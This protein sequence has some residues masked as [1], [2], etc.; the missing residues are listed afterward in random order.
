MKATVNNVMI[1]YEI[2]G[3]AENPVVMLS[4]SL[5]CSSIMWVPQLAILGTSHRVLCF[6]T[7]G[8][9]SSDAPSGPYSLEQLGEDAVGLLDTLGIDQVHFVGLS[10][11]GMIGQS[12]ALNHPERLLSLTLCD[13]TA[14]IPQDALPIWRDRIQTVRS[15]G[16]K[17]VVNETMER[18][19]TPPYLRRNPPE[20]KIIRDQFVATP[21]E[22]YIGC[23]EAIMKLDYLERLTEIRVPVQIMVGE[24]DPGTP[25]TAAEAMH[26][27]ISGSELMVIPSAAH[28]SN[29]EQAETF[30]GALTAFLE[31][32]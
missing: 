20:V 31:R 2:S 24:E 6:D 12:V 10:M 29:I 19:F 22:G 18:W 23:S 25:V 3:K 9:G 7:R 16:L 1:H 14:F 30:N 17:A 13:T 4:H 11:G 5:G 8:H 21:V 28:L 32:R 26:E 27:R 15:K